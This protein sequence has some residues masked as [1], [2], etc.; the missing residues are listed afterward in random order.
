M[1][2]KS[3]QSLI[4]FKL[5]PRLNRRLDCH[6]HSQMARFGNEMGM[7]LPNVGTPRRST[8]DKIL[9]LNCKYARRDTCA[10]APKQSSEPSA[11]VQI[12][13]A[14]PLGVYP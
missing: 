9:V 12:A 8:A 7:K 10:N 11:G 13:P 6:S 3:L 2:V 1:R 4:Q 14:A 5:Y